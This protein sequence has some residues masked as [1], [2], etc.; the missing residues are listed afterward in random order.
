M[1][2]LIYNKIETEAQRII[3]AVASAGLPVKI[4]ETILDEPNY[5]IQVNLP[6]NWT[7]LYDVLIALVDVS[8]YD[9]DYVYAPFSSSSTS[10]QYITGPA[11][12][13]STALIVYKHNN[14]FIY[15]GFTNVGTVITPGTAD[16]FTVR[17][18]NPARQFNTGS[19]I[20]VY[21]FKINT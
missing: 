1:D 18:Y 12:E 7:E 6:E 9:G 4:A 16:Y 21:G 11:A 2:A 17:Y 13:W 8:G 10:G 3:E 5:R 15:R 20:I 19:S 14:E